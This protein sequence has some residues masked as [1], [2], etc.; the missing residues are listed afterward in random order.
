MGADG[1]A[2]PSRFAMQIGDVLMEGEVVNRS[3]AQRV[4]RE[5][6]HQARDPALLEQSQVSLDAL[7]FMVRCSSPALA[8]LLCT[9]CPGLIELCCCKAMPGYWWVCVGGTMRSAKCT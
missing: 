9:C 8:N 4:Y 6:L 7:G 1:P 3:K 5:I 2:M